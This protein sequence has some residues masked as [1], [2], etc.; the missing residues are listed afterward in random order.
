[1][2]IPELGLKG[3]KI[4]V[5]GSAQ[6]IGQATAIRLSELGARLIIAD[7]ADCA[8]TASKCAGETVTEKV[9]LSKRAEAEDIVDRHAKSDDP[10]YGLINCAGLLMRR[11]LDETTEDEINMQIAVN[12]TGSFYLARAALDHM[13]QQKQGRIVLYSSQ[14]AFTG[15]FHGSIP[16]AMTKAAITALIKSFARMGAPHGV[17]VNAVSPGAAD[18]GMFRGGMSQ[19]DIDSFTQMIP[20]QRVADPDELALPT[21]FLMS[22][23]SSYIT[24]TTLHVNGGQLMV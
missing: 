12:Q 24:G 9:D 15:G 18:T 20:M 2:N 19:A 16:Y 10:L 17:T 3:R 5:V 7:I 1:M 14:G 8:D 11:P 21:A 22:D 13:S 6:G 4:L 23:W